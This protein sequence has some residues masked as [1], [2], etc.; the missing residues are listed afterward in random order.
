MELGS[1]VQLLEDKAILVTGATGFLAKIFVEK[2][3]RVQPNV[4]KLY[5]LL[6]AADDK[7][8]TQRLHDEMIGKDLFRVLREKWGTNMDSFFSEKVVA[9]PGESVT[10]LSR[11]WA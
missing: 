5:L 6:R 10:S 1:I 3:L 9:V 4:K 7:S 8:A 11:T 2:I